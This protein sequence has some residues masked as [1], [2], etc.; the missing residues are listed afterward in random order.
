MS[1]RVSSVYGDP[2]NDAEVL[3][4]RLISFGL[5]YRSI[6]I[7]VEGRPHK[8][9]VH[10]FCALWLLLLVYSSSKMFGGSFREVRERLS[11]QR[12]RVNSAYSDNGERAGELFDEMITED[13]VVAKMG[14]RRKIKDMFA[15]SS[16]EEEKVRWS[17]AAGE[18]KLTWLGYVF[19]GIKVIFGHFS[20]PSYF[21]NHFL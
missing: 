15:N 13:N 21:G 16:L 8:W 7:W 18:E 3:R 17:L 11:S 2:L 19:V 5:T 1:G 10:T 12:S 14:S 20:R 6:I 4:I 9:V